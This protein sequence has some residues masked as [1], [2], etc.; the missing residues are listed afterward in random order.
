MALFWWRKAVESGPSAQEVQKVL[1]REVEP[2]GADWLWEIDAQR[3]IRRAN[4]RFAAACGVEPQA[5]DG[6]PLLQVLAGGAWETGS[7]PAGLRILAEKLKA[8]EGFRDLALPVVIGSEERWW[9]LTASP[10]ADAQG[11]FM[12]FLGVGSDVTEHRRSADKINRLAR[13]DSV[14]GLPNRLYIT[15]AM[16]RAC[17]DAETWA[18]RTAIQVTAIT[19]LIELRSQLGYAKVDAALKSVA[20]RFF[21]LANDRTIIGQLSS[22]EFAVIW[23]DAADLPAVEAF[24]KEFQRLLLEEIS[25]KTG[26][27]RISCGS[28]FSPEDGRDG[29]SLITIALDRAYDTERSNVTPTATSL[30][31][32]EGVRV[33]H[34]P[35]QVDASSEQRRVIIAN[36]PVA[37]AG[38]GVLIEESE[39]RLHNA[40]PDPID[41]DAI[42]RI[43][44]LK[45]ELDE[46]IALAEANAPIST[47]MS[48]VGMIAQSVFRFSKDTG[49]IFLA[50]LKPF[51]ASVP[52]ALGT[53]MLIQSI[54]S[55]PIAGVIAPGAALAILAG[56]FQM[57]PKRTRAEDL[58]D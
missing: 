47:K 17:A 42:E 10:R 31:A 8:R 22:G 30:I 45:Q 36:G 40:P 28:A 27:F 15:E 5:L 37:S 52:T 7:F 55:P 53:W 21:S 56:H 23:R 12:G 9:E 39:S 34:F 20:A 6:A 18:S 44:R 25:P 54:C 33:A 49:E 1:L 38:L 58:S 46:L 35:T 13:F 24:S 26:S 19:N 43:R 51:L 11:N 50:G 57:D 3:R 4:P 48:A 41:K 16:S 29:D 2:S 14:T 32:S